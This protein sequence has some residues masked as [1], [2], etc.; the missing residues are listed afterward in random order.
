MSVN[1]HK[2]KCAC[3]H[4]HSHLCVGA[5]VHVNSPM[6]LLLNSCACAVCMICTRTPIIHSLVAS[7]KT[8]TR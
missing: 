5:F 7:R 6:R 4:I 1:V 3:E 8:T 2:C